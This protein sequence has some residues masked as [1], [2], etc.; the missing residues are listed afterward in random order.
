MQ[1]DPVAT[2]V[3]HHLLHRLAREDRRHQVV[4]GE[5][6]H[7]ISVLLKQAALS[8]KVALERGAP[9]SARRSSNTYAA[10]RV[11]S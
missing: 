9:E 10:E 5:Q 7:A 4:Y 1:S 11:A 8:R 6:M 3:A 2:L